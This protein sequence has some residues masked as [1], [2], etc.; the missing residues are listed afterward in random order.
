MQQYLTPFLNWRNQL[1]ITEDSSCPH[2]PTTGQDMRMLPPPTLNLARPVSVLLS[3]GSHH[4]PVR[5]GHNEAV[6]DFTRQ[7]LSCF[8]HCKHCCVRT[9]NIDSCESTR[10]KAVHEWT[11]SLLVLLSSAPRSSPTGLYLELS[12]CLLLRLTLSVYTPWQAYSYDT[13]S[14][15]QSGSIFLQ[16]MKC[17]W[18]RLHLVC[19]CAH[20]QFWRKGVW[21]RGHGGTNQ[22]LDIEYSRYMSISA[23]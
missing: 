2:Q 20:L 13:H 9:R 15:V 4:L 1:L 23:W 14:L 11:F 3:S 18:K 16:K 12:I 5:T 22:H 17:S 8:S 7:P 19:V 10:A 6:S 21:R